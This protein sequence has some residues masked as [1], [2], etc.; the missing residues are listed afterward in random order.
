MSALTENAAPAPFTDEEFRDTLR[1][2]PPSA[3]LVAKVLE[4]DAPLS[5]GEL[6]ENS[7]LPDRTVRYALNRLEESELV[8]SR[9]S[10][11][12]ARKQVYFLTV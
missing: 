4:D 5:Q 8:D 7:L 11:T 2:L 6:A 10:F 1:E 9:Y 12:D 3:K